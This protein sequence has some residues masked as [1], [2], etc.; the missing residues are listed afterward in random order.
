MCQTGKTVEVDDNI[1]RVLTSHNWTE[2]RSI[3]DPY[4]TGLINDINLRII[5]WFTQLFAMKPVKAMIT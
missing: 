4:S 5:L 2:L 3:T 1:E